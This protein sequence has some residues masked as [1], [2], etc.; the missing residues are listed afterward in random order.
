MALAARIAAM[1]SKLRDGPAAT[2]SWNEDSPVAGGLS[3]FLSGASSEGLTTR[4]GCLRPVPEGSESENKSPPLVPREGP[5]VWPSPREAAP[6]AA[7]PPEKGAGPDQSDARGVV[8]ANE[9]EMLSADY[10]QKICNKVAA[11]AAAARRVAETAKEVADQV[12]CTE[13]T[14]KPRK[15]NKGKKHRDRGEEFFGEVAYPYQ[16]PRGKG[17]SAWKALRDFVPQVGQQLH[18]KGTYRG[19]PAECV[20]EVEGLLDDREGQWMKLNLTGTLNAELQ[21]WKRSHSEGFYAN[22]KPLAQDLDPQLDGLFCVRELREVDPLLEWKSNLL[23]LVGSPGELGGLAAVAQDLGYGVNPGGLGTS[24]PPPAS[25]NE[26]GVPERQK[27]LKG[28]DTLKGDSDQEDLFPEEVRYQGGSEEAHDSN[29]GV[30]RGSPAR[31]EYLTLAC[32][33]GVSP[34]IANRLEIIPPENFSLASMEENRCA[35]QGCEREALP[36]DLSG[37]LSQLGPL[38]CKWFRLHYGHMLHAELPIPCKRHSTAEVFPLPMLLGGLPPEEQCWLE[39]AVR[40]VNWLAV[41]DLRLSEKPA[42]PTQKSLLQELQCSFGAL[43]QLGSRLFD[44]ASIESYWKSKSINGYGEEVHCALHF[45]WANVQHSLPTRELAGALDGVEVASGGIKDFLERPMAYLKPEGSRSWMKP[46]RVMV[47]A[48]DWEVVAKGLIERKI[49]DIIPLSQVI[50]VDGK[51]VLGGLFGV[52]KN[53][54][55][56]GVPVLRL[57]MDLRPINKLFESIVGDLNTLPMLGQLLPLEIFPEESV[58]VSSKD[59]KAMF[60]IVGISREAEVR[61]DQVLPHSAMLYRVY[62]DNFD[63]LERLRCQYQSLNIPV[64]EKKSVKSSLVAE[65]QGGFEGNMCIWKP[66]PDRV[67]G[68]VAVEPDPASRIRAL[69]Q[70]NFP[71]SEIFMLIESVLPYELDSVGITP[72]RKYADNSLASFNIWLSSLEL[73]SAMKRSYGKEESPVTKP[74]TPSRLCNILS[75][76]LKDV[77]CKV[78]FS[79]ICL[80]WRW[81]SL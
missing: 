21:E 49:C 58:V 41:G 79:S 22:R 38:L 31:R 10:T 39:A 28:K 54:E 12:E 71:W 25:R 48:E 2:E 8:I 40:A 55:V 1:R 66:I 32:C 15:K 81:Q 52:P 29:R 60:Y 11:A 56:D 23:N 65:M 75:L 57:I 44:E 45:N 30:W 19:V 36:F 14:F 73:N 72:C 47:R 51:P 63:L 67:A 34:A 33:L 6:K 35:A 69:V 53:E 74:K 3:L 64:N 77:F 17:L 42:T 46:P 80:S 50:H 26:G 9:A 37:K 68:Y 78:G 61:R 43:G 27:R 24:P 5:E 59:I 18:L 4:L 20:G 62:L 76:S 70:A 13:E 16:R 7:Q